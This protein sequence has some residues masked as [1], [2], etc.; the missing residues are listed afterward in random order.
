L[1]INR[2][3]NQLTDLFLQ[4]K[5]LAAAT[6]A[7]VKQRMQQ[8]R[9]ELLRLITDWEKSGQGDGALIAND[10]GSKNESMARKFGSLD[11][12]SPGAL[13]DCAAFL[14]N[15]K[16]SYLLILWEEAD[17]HQL[18][19]STLQRL[20][21][22]V[23]APDAVSTPSV[24]GVQRTN[25]RSPSPSTTSDVGM[26][27]MISGFQTRLCNDMLLSS[28]NF[29]HSD[30]VEARRANRQQYFASSIVEEKEYLNK[31]FDQIEKDID[32]CTT[33]CRNIERH[34]NI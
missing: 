25:T 5:D 19:A 6:A 27:E 22:G 3:N 20:D 17:R 10:D 11:R 26:R 23:G 7:I 21:R 18:L 33:R 28:L 34:R 30:L 31:E 16:C 8:M 15:N 29:V 12:Q 14:R 9:T 24:Y 2:F 4:V 32:D 1:S 13:S